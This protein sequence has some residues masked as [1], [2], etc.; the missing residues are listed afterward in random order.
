MPFLFFFFFLIV[1]FESEARKEKKNTTWIFYVFVRN[2]LFLSGKLYLSY[3]SRKV[4]IIYSFSFIRN[5]YYYY[6]GKFISF[7]FFVLW[8]VDEGLTSFY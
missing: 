2:Y 8:N 7:E 4:I 5:Y 1:R 6:F 3:L